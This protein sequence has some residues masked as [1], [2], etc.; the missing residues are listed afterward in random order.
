MIHGIQIV[1][2]LFGLFLSAP[3]E[4]DRDN[5]I[6]KYVCHYTD[7]PIV[8]DGKM[9]ENP[10]VNT[11][12]SELF[13]D[14]E[15]DKKP[16]PLYD[17]WVKMLWDDEYLYVGAWMEEPHI[18]ATY[19]KRESVIFHENDFEI[20]ID[21]DGDTQNYYEI[22]VNALNTIWDLLL[23]KPYNKG[24]KPVTSWNLEGMKTAV[25][26]EGTIN[27]PSDTDKYWS[28][29]FA[30]PWSAL[31]EHAFE[32]R[33]PNSGESWRI[34]FSRVQ[35][36]LDEVDGSYEKTIN[37]STGKSYPEYNWVWSPQGLIN[38]H[39]PQTWGYLQFSYKVVE[40]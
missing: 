33:M 7:A 36:R 17:T 23:T 19:T 34:N 15:G 31:K 27:D 32:N 35:W 20:F 16:K 25:Y 8:I 13:V 40:K 14:I 37:P 38:M 30:L 5:S 2:L 9:D 26:L 10:W 11:S 29:E 3:A 24:G 18:W 39:Q 21:P 4:F 1:F 6:R 28:V 12:E 22:E